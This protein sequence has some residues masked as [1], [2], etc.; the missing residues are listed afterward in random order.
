MSDLTEAKYLSL[1]KAAND[2][3]PKLLLQYSSVKSPMELKMVKGTFQSAQSISEI[4][5]QASAATM[6]PKLVNITSYT[7]NNKLCYKWKLDDQE[8]RS[9]ATDWK[10]GVDTKGGALL[11]HKAKSLMA[12][13]PWSWAEW[14]A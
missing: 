14:K 4:A 12:R 8:E 7:V 2:L 6:T 10:T 3:Y 13:P 1:D 5:A 11:L 9:Y